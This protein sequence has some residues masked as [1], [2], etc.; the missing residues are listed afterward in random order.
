MLFCALFFGMVVAQKTPNYQYQFDGEVKWMKLT[1][2]GIV[3]A[4]TG[5][6]LVGLKAHNASPH[7]KL[8]RVKKVKE[9]NLEFI[10]NTPY[11]VIKPRGLF[12]HTVVV[13][14]IKGKVVFDSKEAK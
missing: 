11:V 3:L 7:F 5:E 2:S 6:A 10:T 12:N 4:S 1:E 9:E 8:D 14:M 13:D